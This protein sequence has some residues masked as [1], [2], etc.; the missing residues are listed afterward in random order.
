MLG[1]VHLEGRVRGPPGLGRVAAPFC[2]VLTCCWL[3]FT[4]QV[5]CGDRPFF[6]ALESAPQLFD[7]IQILRAAQAR[8]VQGKASERRG[9]T[10]FVRLTVF[11]LGR[12]AQGGGSGGA[13]A[14]GA[15]AR[16]AGPAHAPRRQGHARQHL[17][18]LPARRLAHG[19]Q[20]ACLQFL[21]F[22]LLLDRPS[23]SCVLARTP[24]PWPTKWQS[25]AA[26]STP[27]CPPSRQSWTR[28]T[29]TCG[30]EIATSVINIA[31]S[32]RCCC[33]SPTMPLNTKD[34]LRF[35]MFKQVKEKQR[36]V[37]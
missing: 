19:Q 24:W 6:L 15:G 27:P 1:T 20:I 28:P 32:L 23:S 12:P 2:L 10:F 17:H 34:L 18:G 33:A 11:F 35:D 37:I 26:S 4:I 9:C 13:R 29:R 8:L 25:W 36:L 21:V 30:R 5:D 31:Y 22:Q 3:Q 16:R 7:W 14:A